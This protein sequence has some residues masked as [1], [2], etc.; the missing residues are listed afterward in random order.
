MLPSSVRRPR[1]TEAS[2]GS[3]WANRSRNRECGNCIRS[4]SIIHEGGHERIVSNLLSRKY[5]AAKDPPLH[6]GC[7]ETK[8][9]IL[10]IL[11]LTR[12]DKDVLERVG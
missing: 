5:I 6:L 3:W 12:A 11:M 8:S 7:Q 10:Q 4:C 1:A 9:D 2:H